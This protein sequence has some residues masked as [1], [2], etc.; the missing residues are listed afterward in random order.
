MNYWYPDI[1][2]WVSALA[3]LI[4][5]TLINLINVRMY[6]EFEF[7]TAII[8]VVAIIGMIIFGTYSNFYADGSLSRLF[9]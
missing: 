3:C 1:P 4:I 2:Q 7:F 8:K 9:C 6:G 5:I